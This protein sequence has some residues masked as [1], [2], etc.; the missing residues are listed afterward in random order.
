MNSWDV[1]QSMMDLESLTIQEL[2]QYINGDNGWYFDQMT[3]YG[4]PL[5]VTKITTS[6]DPVP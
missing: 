2:I 1:N 6:E 5:S 3:D 4:S